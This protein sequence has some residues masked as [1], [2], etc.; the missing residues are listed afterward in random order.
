[1]GPSSLISENVS[2]SSCSFIRSMI[3]LSENFVYDTLIDI[4]R[5][6]QRNNRSRGIFSSESNRQ[7]RE[8]RPS[9]DRIA[10]LL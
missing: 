8:I 3:R 9:S 6:A 2:Y 1:M 7:S 4:D 5:L 10:W